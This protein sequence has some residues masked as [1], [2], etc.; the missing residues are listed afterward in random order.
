MLA[1]KIP[2]KWSDRSIIEERFPV[3]IIRRKNHKKISQKKWI[4]NFFLRVCYSP[5]DKSWYKF[6]DTQLTKHPKRCIASGS[7]LA[8]VCVFERNS[9]VSQPTFSSQLHSKPNNNFT[10]GFG[11]NTNPGFGA[12]NSNPSFGGGGNSNPGFGGSSWNAPP[13]KPQNSNLGGTQT[14]FGYIPPASSAFGNNNFGGGSS[15]GNN[16]FGGGSMGQS[17][18]G[19]NSGGF[20]GGN[21][22]SGGHGT[23]AYGFKPSKPSNGFGW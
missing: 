11:F 6:D 10:G 5:A 9:G 16:N 2:I 13:S 22:K 4:F 15:F 14:K 19:F 21:Q 18:G 8:Y 17:G 1:P 3:V 12:G 7:E 23:E 20:G